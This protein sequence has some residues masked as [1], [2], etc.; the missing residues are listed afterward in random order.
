MFCKYCGK[1]IEGTSTFCKY[2]GKAQNVTTGEPVQQMQA[3]Q[4]Q[5]A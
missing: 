3:E 5:T 1:E 2:C 4:V